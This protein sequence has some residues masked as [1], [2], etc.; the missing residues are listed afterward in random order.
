MEFKSR[1]SHF[2]V[3]IISLLFLFSCSESESETSVVV[4]D[5]YLKK[6]LEGAH[7]SAAYMNLRNTSNYKIKVRGLT[8]NNLLAEFHQTVNRDSVMLRMNKLDLL[9]LDPKSEI[10]LE[11]GKEHIMLVGKGILNETKGI[12]CVLIVENR[13][14]DPT[15]KRVPI[16]FEIRK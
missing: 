13:N 4:L 5:A 6:P 2:F 16:F 9:T 7:S 10:T 3:L 1:R 12:D 8:C 14:S 15:L 11:P